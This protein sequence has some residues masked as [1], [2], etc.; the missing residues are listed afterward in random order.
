[1]DRARRALKSTLF[2]VCVASATTAWSLLRDPSVRADGTSAP[3]M[4]SVTSASSI[5]SGVPAIEIDAEQMDVDAKGER[6]TLSGK[7]VVRRGTSMVLRAP[8]IEAHYSPATSTT[9]ARVTRLRALEGVE[10][11]ASGAHA[12]ANEASI[13]LATQRA[14]L[15]GDVRVVRGD[16]WLTADALEIDLA[17][18]KLS[19]RKVRASLS[20]ALPS[21]TAS[22]PS[23][24][25]TS[26]SAS[27]STP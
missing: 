24:V 14:T 1:M 12:R 10:I 4:T 16:G 7:V 27:A 22:A 9:P 20:I 25:L 3:I 2:V 26:A 13:D 6:A 21:V 19:L 5:A 15:L 11:E 18:G 8:K 23:S 17:T